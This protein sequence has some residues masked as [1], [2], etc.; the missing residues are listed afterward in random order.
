MNQGTQGYSLTKKTEGRKSRETVLLIT[1][2][3]IHRQSAPRNFQ[4]QEKLQRFIRVF[5]LIQTE[6]KTSDT[7]PCE[8]LN[9]RLWDRAMVLKFKLFRLRKWKDN[10]L[11]LYVYS[12]RY[13][14]YCALILLHIALVYIHII[15]IQQIHKTS[16][17][18]NLSVTALTELCLLIT[19]P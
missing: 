7:L 14:Q 4:W 10:T 15:I 18:V 2:L 3:Q 8:S 9:I 5:V 19:F 1:Y 13:L 16:K 11:N 6:K 12:G 17:H